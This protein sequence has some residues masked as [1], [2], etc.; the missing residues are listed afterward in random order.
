MLCDASK[1]SYIDCFYTY[2]KGNPT[3]FRDPLGL[4]TQFGVSVSGTIFAGFF[5][6]GGGATIG[7]STNGTI[8]GTS[9]FATEQANGM[10]GVGGYAGVGA[11]PYA[12]HTDG[13]MTPSS[14]SW[15]PYAEG[16]LGWGPA[17]SV[18]GGTDKDGNWGLAGAGPYGL[19]KPIPGVGIGVAIGVGASYSSTQVTD[20]LGDIW[21]GI[22]DAW[23]KEKI[24]CREKN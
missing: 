8:A 4:D 2:V 24:Q 22:R 18:G 7:I 14:G 21:K 23:K 11:S 16:D 1:N 5:G 10:V 12:G 15:T 6:G 13:P 19:L 17:I 9:F 20:S 3:V